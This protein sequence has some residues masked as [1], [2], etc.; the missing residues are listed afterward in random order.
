MSIILEL[1]PTVQETISQESR[2]EGVS[3]MDHAALLICLASAIKM[4]VPQSPFQLAVKKFLTRHALD[5]NLVSTVFEELVRE[6]QG[7]LDAGKSTENI[8]VYLRNWR[9][10]NVHE[11]NA[12]DYASLSTDL[13]SSDITPEMHAISYRS[14]TSVKSHRDPRDQV[15]ERLMQWQ[16]ED[17]PSLKTQIPTGQGETPT[18]ALFRKW[19]DEDAFMTE[20]EKDAEDRLWKEVETG[21]K[22]NRLT[23][24]A[25]R[26]AS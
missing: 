23:F 19:S 26:L 18:Q 24:G 14:A 1:P 2:L 11:S 25:E 7:M 6:C 12:A 4:T 9:D 3:E 5:V 17:S 10:A 16:S 15:R 20:E 22:E 8:Q 21:L 13:A